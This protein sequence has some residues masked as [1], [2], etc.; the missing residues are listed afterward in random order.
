[1]GEG[2]CGPTQSKAAVST[3][4][5]RQRRRCTVMFGFTL[6]LNGTMQRGAAVFAT[7]REPPPSWAAQRFSRMR[8]VEAC[9]RVKEF[10]VQV[11][12]GTAFEPHLRAGQCPC[13]RF[14]CVNPWHRWDQPLCR[15][16]GPVGAPREGLLGW[17][18]RSVP[19][20][21]GF[22]ALRNGHSGSGPMGGPCGGKLTS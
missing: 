7:H 11:L 17:S 14:E 20:G 6:S 1:M 10:R 3:L 13:R 16:R 2:R 4:S 15:P 22:F 12:A 5:S 8:P 19:S 9:N 21:K 18:L